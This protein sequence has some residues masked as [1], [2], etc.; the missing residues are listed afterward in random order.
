MSDQEL[1]SNQQ[2][3]D[4]ELGDVSGGFEG[5]LIQFESGDMRSPLTLGNLWEGNDP[6]PQTGG[7]TKQLGHP[8]R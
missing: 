5:V 4:V 2:L 1:T 3:N 7:G 6:P 8:R